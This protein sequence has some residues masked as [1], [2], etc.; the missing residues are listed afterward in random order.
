MENYN[1]KYNAFYFFIFLSKLSL[2]NTL[3]QV[4]LKLRAVVMLSGERKGAESGSLPRRKSLFLAESSYDA[5]SHGQRGCARGCFSVQ[6]MM[7]M[8]PQATILQHIS[9]EP[10]D[11]HKIFKGTDGKV[12]ITL[13]H[14]TS[15]TCSWAG[16]RRVKDQN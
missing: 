1:I 4:L 12:G 8:V 11:C 13:P 2:V 16:L 9:A 5:P 6:K 3:A 7:N 10:L 14:P 15:R